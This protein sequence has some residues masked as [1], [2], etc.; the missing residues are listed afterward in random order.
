[1]KVLHIIDRFNPT[2]GQEINFIAK[3]KNDDIDLTILTSTSLKTWNIKSHHEVIEAD[4]D[5]FKTNKVSIIRQ[6]L[7]FEIG[8]KLWIKGI[9]HTIENLKPEVV[10]VH[11][12]EYITFMRIILWYTVNHSLGYR[13]YTDT[14]SLPQFTRGS[15]FRRVYY[16]LLK[17]IIIPLVNKFHVIAFYTAEENKGLLENFYK[18]KPTL[19]K[20]FV[21][22]ADLNTFR[23]NENERSNKRLQYQLKNEEILI[24]FSGRICI[25]KGP[26]LILEA[27]NKIK[28]RLTKPISLLLIGFHDD[29]YLDDVIKPLIDSSIRVIIEKAQPSRLMSG[30]FSA[31]DFAVFP[32][33]STLSSLECQACRLPVIMED[34]TTNIQRAKMGG[35][36]YEIGNLDAMAD[37]MLQLINDSAIR[38]R[39]SEA[40]YTYVSQNYNYLLSL[41]QMERILREHD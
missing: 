2:L 36:L 28:S 16:S 9:I 27:L 8:E 20:P 15:F 33:E 25:Q 34:N 18:V 13:L 35:L 19:I 39:L 30:Y 23:F 1:M 41:R 17:A 7:C 21:I 38:Y 22:G 10:Y 40:G 14:H 29:S 31:A 37:K 24:V 5:Y 32:L 6:D 12:I 4:H 3:N 26:H 11:G